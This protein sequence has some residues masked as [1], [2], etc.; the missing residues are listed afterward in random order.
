VDQGKAGRVERMLYAGSSLTKAQ[1]VF[2]TAVKHRP[3]TRLTI[4]LRTRVP[5]WWPEE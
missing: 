1:E 4:R 2:A 5:R 3:R